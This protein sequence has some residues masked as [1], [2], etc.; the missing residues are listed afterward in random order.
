M[1][2]I[3]R[4]ELKADWPW[5]IKTIQ[6]KHEMH[7]DVEQELF[8]NPE[9]E[10]VKDLTHERGYFIQMQ[11][12]DQVFYLQYTMAYTITEPEL[13]LIGRSLREVIFYE[14]FIEYETERVKRLSSVSPGKQE[15]LN[16]N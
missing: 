16:L 13:R 6:E 5:L 7:P 14:D 15:G 9:F 2:T 1:F 12:P 3:D 11:Y 8:N 4:A 10:A